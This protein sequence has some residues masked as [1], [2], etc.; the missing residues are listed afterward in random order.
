MPEPTRPAPSMQARGQRGAEA[1]WGPP[2]RLRIGDLTPEQR[3]LVAAL[4][5]AQREANNKAALVSETSRAA[6]SEVS[7]RDAQQPTAAA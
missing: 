6:E 2:R 1:R 4:V 3:R 5:D 7:D